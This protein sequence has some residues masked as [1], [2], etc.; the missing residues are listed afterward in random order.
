MK[1]TKKTKTKKTKKKKMMKK[2]KS[3]KKQ[4][5]SLRKQRRDENDC[6]DETQTQTQTNQKRRFQQSVETI[7]SLLASSQSQQRSYLSWWEIAL[8]IVTYA[9]IN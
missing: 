9:F 7:I 6:D 2:K 8:K 3:S 5:W 1:K 4:R